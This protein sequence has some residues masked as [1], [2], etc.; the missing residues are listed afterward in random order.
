MT[1]AQSIDVRTAH[2]RIGWEPSPDNF[3]MVRYHVVSVDHNRIDAEA[4]IKR[5]EEEISKVDSIIEVREPKRGKVKNSDLEYIFQTFDSNSPPKIINRRRIG[6][7]IIEDYRLCE[8][9]VGK[10][11]DYIKKLYSE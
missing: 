4:K 6:R 2:I 11:E 1:K 7:N 3:M 5:F 8:R 9:L 10:V